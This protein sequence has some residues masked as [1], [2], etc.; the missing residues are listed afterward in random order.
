M[1]LQEFDA[2]SGEVLRTFKGTTAQS[3]GPPYRTVLSPLWYDRSDC[4]CVRYHP[5]GDVVASGSEDGTIRLWALN[6]IAAR[7]GAP[8]KEGAS[9]SLD[10]S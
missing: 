7:D 3:G 1:W 2:Q 8:V 4:R 5:S 6:T 9:A 10:T